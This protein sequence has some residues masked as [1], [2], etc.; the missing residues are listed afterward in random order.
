M[1]PTLYAVS[2]TTLECT[3]DATL[4]NGYYT[5]YTTSDLMPVAWHK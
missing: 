1:P 4:N 2:N 3:F 5:P